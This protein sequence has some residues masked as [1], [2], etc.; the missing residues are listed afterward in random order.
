MWTFGTR[1]LRVQRQVGPR[2]RMCPGGGVLYGQSSVTVTVLCVF[3]GW[4]PCNVMPHALLAGIVMGSPVVSAGLPATEIPAEIGPGVSVDN[5][6]VMS[7][8]DVASVTEVGSPTRVVRA[9]APGS[10]YEVRVVVPPVT[11]YDGMLY[12]CSVPLIVFLVKRWSPTVPFSMDG[13]QFSSSAVNEST[14]Q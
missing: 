3:P 6:A 1:R 12:S 14:P 4:E 8:G 7:V 2:T 10:S 13:P 11:W 5:L 9:C